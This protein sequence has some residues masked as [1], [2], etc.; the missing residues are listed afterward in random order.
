MLN[1][2]NWYSTLASII[3]LVALWFTVRNHHRK[4]GLLIRGIY[5]ISSSI[6][7]N[8][9]FVSKFILENLKDRSVTI[10]AVYLRVG[11]SHYIQ[12]EDFEEAPLLLK[13]F[14]TYQKELGPV[15]F[16]GSNMYRVRLYASSS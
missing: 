2:F 14:E 3:G 9:A 8:D 12:L 11:H 16:Y 6:D 1:R 4:S 13:P 7:C 15:Q 5:S 10:F